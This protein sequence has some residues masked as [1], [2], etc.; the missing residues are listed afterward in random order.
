MHKYSRRSVIERTK[1]RKGEEKL[2]YWGFSYGSVLGATFAAL[3][4]HRV[5]RVILDGVEE[6][7]DYYSTA[8]AMNLK[9][10]DKIMD[11]FYEYCAAAGP[12]KCALNSG[13]SDPAD[14]QEIFESLVSDIKENPFPVPASGTRGPEI[15]TYNDVMHL[16]RSSLYR[17][18]AL[19][20][21]TANYLA[22]LQ[23]NGSVFADF[24]QKQ[25]EPSCPLQNCK[26]SGLTEPCYPD[27]G[28]AIGMGIFC[29]DGASLSDASKVAFK[30]YATYLFKQS[31]WLGELWAPIAVKCYHWKGKAAWRIKS[32]EPLLLYLKSLANRK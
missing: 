5:G 17:P 7:T 31:R 1:W 32:G 23:G 11:K 13:T 28:L 22:D 3:Q 29:S 20:P 9:D 10:T 21:Q 4:P 27:G 8:W 26:G 15:I 12:E 6:T 2:Q 18:L 25:N 19:S 16:I 30:R 14:I 24:K